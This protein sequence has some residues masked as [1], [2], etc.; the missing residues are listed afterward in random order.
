[1]EVGKSNDKEIDSLFFPKEY[2]LNLGLR[3]S[4]SRKQYYQ[5]FNLHFRFSEEKLP[6]FR[7]KIINR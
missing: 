5:I 6:N 1:L 2:F 4:Q 7:Y 3:Q